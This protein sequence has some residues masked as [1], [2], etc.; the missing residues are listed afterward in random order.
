MNITSSIAKTIGGEIE[1][2]INEN[3]AI[4]FYANDNVNSYQWRD[5][6]FEE[7][8]DIWLNKSADTRQELINI[9]KHHLSTHS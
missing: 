7:S 2:L 6:R 8:Y 9:F 4:Q 3:P 5:T 1:I